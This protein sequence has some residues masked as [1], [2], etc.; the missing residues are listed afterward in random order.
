MGNA[1][2]WALVGM[3]AATLL[4]C[5]PGEPAVGQTSRGIIA[6]QS[7]NKS[8][9]PAAVALIMDAQ[10]RHKSEPPTGT[11]YPMRSVVCS[12]SLIAPDT[13][14][15]AAHCIG[16]SEMLNPDYV[17][18]DESYH[19]SFDD[20]LTNL[21]NPGPAHTTGGDAGL[22]VLPGD[23]LEARYFVAHPE[24]KV[25][26]IIGQ[27]DLGK[28]PDIGLIFLKRPKWG[29]TPAALISRAEASQI[30]KGAAV[31]VVGW[32]MT[33]ASDRTTFARKM[34]AT[35]VVNE[36]GTYA[37]QIGTDST[38]PRK[39]NGDSGGP[40]FLTVKASS[41][42]TERVIGV[43]SR[44]HYTETVNNCSKGNIDTR[45]DAYL[46]WIDATMKKGCADG[47]RRVWCDVPGIPTP[48]TDFGDGGGCALAGAPARLTAGQARHATLLLLLAGL[49]LIRAR[50][51]R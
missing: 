34:C 33:N 7:C 51:R 47:G 37:M 32:G 17:V 36:V 16:L 20:D 6:G 38:K 13:V 48:D 9:H 39:C 44:A 4:A 40:S 31:R 26:A 22:P 28:I 10:I 11:K 5:G 41:S 49:A 46:D 42:D 30:V 3:W 23:S 1:T 45:V 50:R 43:T 14:L 15:T 27:K 19:V 29:V 12:G 2:R 21:A 24:F 25:N 8:K 18:Y 35:S